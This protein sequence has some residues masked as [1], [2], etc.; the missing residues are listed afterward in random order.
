[1]TQPNPE[2]KIDICHEGHII[3]VDYAGALG[4]AKNH[5]TDVIPSFPST[6]TTEAFAGQGNQSLLETECRTQATT[7]TVTSTTTTV[8]VTTIRP[9]TTTTAPS[10]TVPALP[11]TTT[12]VIPAPLLIDLPTTTTIPSTTSTTTS[13][14]P[15]IADTLPVTG[16]G[17]TGLLVASVVLISAGAFI[18]KWGRKLR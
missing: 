12:T 1:M 2:H 3:N 15:I 7:T 8:P 4:H 16:S 18:T 5:D 17:A 9:S 14:L 13:T 10:T 6:E 11:T